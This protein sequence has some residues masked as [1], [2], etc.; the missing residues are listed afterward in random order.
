MTRI[1]VIADTHGYLDPT[2]REH[3]KTCSE[4]WHAGDFGGVEVID[5]LAS[6]GKTLRLVHGNIDDHEVRSCTAEDL[7]FKCELQS[8][9]M[10]HIA[11]Y[12]GRYHARA[13]EII[14]TH[15]PGIVVCGHS[16]ILKVIYDKK[17][18]H[19]HINP[20]SCG[21]HGFHQIR[22]AIRFTIDGKNI[23]D[24]QVIELGHRG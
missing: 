6:W 10:T 12:P 16:H 23:K 1:G 3:F 22:T 5:E 20:G 14:G 18:K 15:K 2:L 21:K 17:L 11:G 19:L 7:F 13:R 24:M 4:I 9:F 8:V